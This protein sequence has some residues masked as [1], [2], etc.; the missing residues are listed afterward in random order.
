MVKKDQ[1]ADSPGE[2][3][4]EEYGG[5][6][7]NDIVVDILRMVIAMAPGFSAALAR[8]VE[9]QA[10]EKWAGDRPYIPRPGRQG[11]SERNAAIKR[12]YWERGERIGLLER[13]YGLKRTR[14][15]EIIKS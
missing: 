4:A 3:R 2:A 7:P 13:R 1:R 8:Q 12:D 5:D 6:Q 9:A 11:Y 15:W 10:K 14:L